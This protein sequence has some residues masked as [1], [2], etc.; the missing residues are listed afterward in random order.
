MT[1]A[2]DNICRYPVKGLSPDRLDAVTLSADAA[3]PY[4]RH[5]A[6]ALGS[7]PVSGAISQWMPKSSFL[8]LMRNEK[9]AQLET[10]FDD[11]TATLTIR[12]GGNQVAR[13]Q[14]TQKIGRTMIEDFFAAFMKE[15]ARGRP[16]LVEAA[17]GHALSD[18]DRPVISII[19]LNSVKDLAR[20]VGSEIDPARFRGNFMIDGLDAWAEFD[21]Y[22][23]YIAVGGARLEIVMPI[24]RCAAT[25]VNPTTAERDLN[26]PKDMMRGYGHIDCGVFAHVI[27]GGTVKAGDE[28][29][30]V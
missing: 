19:N 26:I 17:D 20:V 12:R 23:K 11:T 8:C 15:E 18:H 3:L 30:I 28:I 4:D 25:N 13:G 22:G 27:E 21:L 2:L 9:L 5:Y 6:L 16:K 10:Q 7:T 14:L 29:R 24:D 1:I